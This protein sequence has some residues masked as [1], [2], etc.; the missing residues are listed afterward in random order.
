MSYQFNVDRE[1]KK[2]GWGW[3]F[4]LGI[5]F[6]ILGMFAIG[7]SGLTTIISVITLGVIILIAGVFVLVDAFSSW[8]GRWGGFLLHDLVGILYIIVGI[9]LIQNPIMASVSLTL[10]LGIFY[11]ALGVFRVIYSLYYQGIAWKWGL[12]NGLIAAILGILILSNW[13][14]SSLFIIGL[15]VGIDLLFTGWTYIMIALTARA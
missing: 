4:A 6:V 5:L 15:F 11:L 9:I 14:A 12:F 7:M 3:L 13:P 2:V 8:W 10:L 1:L